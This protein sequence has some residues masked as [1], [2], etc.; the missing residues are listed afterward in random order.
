M[1]PIQLAFKPLFPATFVQRDNRFR[2]RIQI[3]ERIE[4]AHLPNSGRLGELLVPGRA[5]WLAAADL[6]RNPQ[7]RTAYDL[8]LVECA[9]RLVSVDARVP[10][11]LVAEALRHGQLAGFRGYSTVQH[12]VHLGNSRIDFRLATA[13]Q[14]PACWIEVKSVTLIDPK[15]GTAHF[16]DAPTLRG[17]RHVNELV[18][19]VE[20]GARAAVVFVVQ[21]EDAQ[22]FEPHDQADPTFGQALRQA[23]QAGVEVHAWRCHVSRNVIRL[24]DTIPVVL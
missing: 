22:R 16:P 21:R 19:A 24:A 11:K 3:A 10:G 15:T 8:A 23:A 17:R 13:T 6:Q 4:A 5:V 1:M 12:E 14:G 7:R 9:G 2:V 18:R 20:N